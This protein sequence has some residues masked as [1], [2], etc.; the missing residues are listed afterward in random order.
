VENLNELAGRILADAGLIQPDSEFY[1][2]RP[3]LIGTNDYQL[4]LFNGDVGL[5]L[6]DAEA[7]GELRAFFIDATGALRRVLPARLPAHET[8]FAMTVHKSQGSEFDRVLLVLPD[9]D[10]PLVTR[11]LLY[12]GITRARRGVEVWADDAVLRGGIARRIERSS[13]LHDALWN[14]PRRAR[15]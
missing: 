8:S 6:R 11:E 15:G 12:T 5:I 3:V 13:G 10:T 1:H 4:R 9:R 2:G 7:G 14:A